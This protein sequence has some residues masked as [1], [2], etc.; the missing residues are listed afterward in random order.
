M[1]K[2]R[3]Q[4]NPDIRFIVAAPTLLQPLFDGVANVQFVAVNKRQSPMELYRQ[5]S[6]YHPDMVADMHHVNRIL[7]SDLMFRL[8]G[9]PVHSI[10]KERCRRRRMMRRH[11]KSRAPLTPSWK[12]YDN[13]FDACGLHKS[14]IQQQSSTYWPLPVA[15]RPTTTVGI[16]PTAQHPGK[17]WPLEHTEQLIRLLSQRQDIHI[18]LFGGKSDKE[19]LERW[20]AKYPHT[21]SLAGTMCFADELKAIADLDLMVSMDSSNMH[22]A[23]A[24]QTPVLSIWGATHPDAGF[25]GWRQNPQWAVQSALPCRPCSTFGN[26]PCRQNGYPCLRTITPEQVFAKILELTTS[27]I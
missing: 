12:R 24:V 1:L 21:Q 22:F 13:V 10:H 7:W 20:A 17:I 25:Y 3:A 9:I 27:R 5:L 2:A 23:S 11:N 8:H 14:D 15:P 6:A 18:Q 16:A 4:A 19:Q 26:K